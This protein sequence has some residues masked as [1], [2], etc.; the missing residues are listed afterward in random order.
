MNQNDIKKLEMA[1]KI[2]YTKEN[3]IGEMESLVRSLN[4][5]IERLKTE[6]NYKPNSL[7]VIQSNSID[8]SCA[9]L[10]ALYEAEELIAINEEE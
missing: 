2:K 1:V 4:R 10:Y 9:R 7:G 6:P 3:L 8:L 5:E